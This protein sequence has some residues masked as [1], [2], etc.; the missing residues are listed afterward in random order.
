MEFKK[1]NVRNHYVAVYWPSS[2]SKLIVDETTA[3]KL[4]DEVIV[5]GAG[6]DAVHKDGTPV[7]SIGDDVI[8]R[9]LHGARIVKSSSGFYKDQN[10]GFVQ[11]TDI[12]CVLS[13][14]KHTA[15]S[16]K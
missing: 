13:S 14:G 15:I 12:L 2:T 6:P 7:V 3:N 1:I 11:H 16:E 4:A 5:I 8:V 10:V 9:S